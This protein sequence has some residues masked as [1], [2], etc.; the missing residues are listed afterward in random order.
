M[1]QIM[2]S[3]DDGYGM[4]IASED[5]CCI[6]CLHESLNWSTVDIDAPYRLCSICKLAVLYDNEN[7]CIA[8]T[9][10]QA[11]LDDTHDNFT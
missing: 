9:Y 8:C 1:Q 4:Q 10:V 11:F 5:D 2:E 6:P 7:I 3:F